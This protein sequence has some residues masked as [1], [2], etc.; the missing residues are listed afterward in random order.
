MCTHEFQIVDIQSDDISYFIE[1]NIT[2]QFVIT[3][4]GKTED[5]GNIICNIYDYYPYFYIK[6]PETWN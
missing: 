1:D 5:D 2:R 6:F 3:L 4:Y